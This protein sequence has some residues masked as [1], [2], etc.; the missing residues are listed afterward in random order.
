MGR[1]S[2]SQSCRRVEVSQ[3]GGGLAGGVP[4]GLNLFQSK[5]VDALGVKPH[6]PKAHRA[7]WKSCSDL[8]GQLCFVS[9]GKGTVTG[10]R[11]RLLGRVQSQTTFLQQQGM[12][13]GRREALH[14]GITE[15]P[16]LALVLP[17]W[18]YYSTAQGTPSSLKRRA[19]LP[20]TTRWGDN[21]HDPGK[22]PEVR[23]MCLEMRTYSSQ[24]DSLAMA[25]H[26]DPWGKLKP[27]SV[28]RSLGAQLLLPGLRS[29]EA[30]ETGCQRADKPYPNASRDILE[31]SRGSHAYISLS[32]SSCISF[33]V[34]K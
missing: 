17:S 21:T 8:C 2:M 5:R 28:R 1:V 26:R 16:K 31:G 11:S 6:S 3:G 33:L 32:Q 34:L 10:W 23:N 9:V 30:G 13:K 29:M 19:P 15:Q 27:D 25:L 14:R 20:W 7:S 12:N 4:N 24:E 18:S 22:Y